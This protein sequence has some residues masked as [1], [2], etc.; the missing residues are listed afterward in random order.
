MAKSTILDAIETGLFAVVGA[1]SE[2]QETFPRIVEKGKAS[3]EPKLGVAK[4]VGQF[5]VKGAES[6]LRKKSGDLIDQISE[7]VFQLFDSGEEVNLSSTTDGEEAI[8]R[9]AKNGTLRARTSRP[10][11][12]KGKS[13]VVNDLPI[14]GYTTLSAQQVIARLNSLTSSELVS[15]SIY[16]A[17]HRNRSSILRAI[18]LK[19]Q[20]LDSNA[21]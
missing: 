7:L 20:S 16:E 11:P 14:A 15:I 5:A 10:K 21:R 13:Q 19:R 1:V 9:E 18:E 17:S 2:L 8:P 12:S 4:F 3:L 6:E